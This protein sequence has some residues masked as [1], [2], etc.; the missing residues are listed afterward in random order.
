MDVDGAAGALQ[1]GP[2]K[3]DSVAVL[4][5]QALQAQDKALLEKCASQPLSCSFPLPFL[6]STHLVCGHRSM[7]CNGTSFVTPGAIKCQSLPQH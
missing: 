5:G 2:L 6:L 4:L 3:A 1:A 7:S